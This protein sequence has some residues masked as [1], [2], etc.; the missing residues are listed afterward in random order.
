VQT[1]GILALA[2]NDAR[3]RVVMLVPANLIDQIEAG[4]VV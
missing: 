4:F 3:P 2:K 1:Q